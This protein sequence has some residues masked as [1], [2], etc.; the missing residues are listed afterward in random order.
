MKDFGSWKHFLGIKVSRL[1]EDIFL[2]Q[3]K[4]ALELSRKIGMGACKPTSTPMEENLKLRMDL[5]QVQA[6]K[7]R[8]RD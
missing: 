5:N 4:Y 2:S 1:K 3:R 6:N 8:I 7:K